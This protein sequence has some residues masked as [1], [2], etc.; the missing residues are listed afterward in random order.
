MQN[1]SESALLRL[2]PE[3]LDDILEDVTSSDLRACSLTS[4][5][6]HPLARSRTLRSIDLRTSDYYPFMDRLLRALWF[7]RY[8]TELYTHTR[9]FSV[10][11]GPLGPAHQG[12][13]RSARAIESEE[14][15][16]LKEYA[17]MGHAVTEILTCIPSLHSF[18]MG[19]RLYQWPS[20]LEIFHTPLFL[21]V[22]SLSMHNCKFRSTAE[23]CQMLAASLPSVTHLDIDRCV[24]DEIIEHRSG[25]IY[26]RPLVH[27]RSYN[28]RFSKP[29]DDY[30]LLHELSLWTTKG[31]LQS[32]ACRI[33]FSKGWYDVLKGPIGQSLKDAE[34]KVDPNS[35]HSV[36]GMFYTLSADSN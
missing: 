16:E 9:S 27:I 19:R 34:F 3:I 11:W 10:S 15:P 31:S 35:L 4:C 21:G 1:L 13:Q 25:P 26:E 22:T 23:F 18:S 12:L 28:N 2:P 29:Y 8:A 30:T 33:S 5:I 24:F 32:I 20:K 17:D 14:L 6:L 36:L 7:A